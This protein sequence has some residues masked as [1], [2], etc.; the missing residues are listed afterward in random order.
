MAK[1]HKFDDK[2]DQMMCSSR[3]VAT[4]M[5]GVKLIFFIIMAIVY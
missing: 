2:G 1:P 4:N 5:L 3:P